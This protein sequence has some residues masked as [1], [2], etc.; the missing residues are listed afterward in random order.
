[1]GWAKERCNDRE[2]RREAAERW[3]ERERTK[4]DVTC[5]SC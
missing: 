4:R 1:M 5:L 2:V 3:K